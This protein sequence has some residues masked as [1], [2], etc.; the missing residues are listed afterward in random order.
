MK[1]QQENFQLNGEHVPD[2]P[3]VQDGDQTSSLPPDV[4]GDQP[5]PQDISTFFATK[6]PTMEPKATKRRKTIHS[7]AAGRAITE[8]DVALDIR[9]HAQNIK[10]PTSITKSR[11]S[12]TPRKM[13]KK[14]AAQKLPK[15]S[16]NKKSR[17]TRGPSG[18]QI[19]PVD[20]SDSSQDSDDIP[21]EEKCCV[22]HRF[23]PEEL[24]RC[25]QLFIVKWAACDSPGCLHWTHLWFC[26]DVNVLR[27]KDKFFCPCHGGPCKRSEE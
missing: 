25:A 23:Q 14:N 5:E 7:L 8:D 10:K 17:P 19:I 3:M 13:Q 22:C 1:R 15:K 9:N 4:S 16:S 24:Q 18:M 20:D 26:C 21:E 12:Q 6:M 11:K 27:S 2:Q